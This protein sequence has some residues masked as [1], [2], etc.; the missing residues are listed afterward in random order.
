VSS[1]EGEV[2]FGFQVSDFPTPRPL[3]ASA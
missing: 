1:V 3:G 2:G